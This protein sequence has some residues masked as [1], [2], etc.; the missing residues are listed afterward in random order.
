MS[1]DISGKVTEVFAVQQVSDKFK[2]REFVIERSSEGGTNTYT[3][4][5]KF[6]LTQERCN[7]IEGVKTGEE[8]KISFNIKGNRWEK[9]GKVSYFTNLEAWRIEKLSNTANA[10]TSAAPEFTSDDIP[11]E[12]ED[13][14]PF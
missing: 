11:P 12:I 5:I 10:A 4:Y 3:D 7:L 6:Q 1:F 14:L 13:D 2:K 8:L 9:D